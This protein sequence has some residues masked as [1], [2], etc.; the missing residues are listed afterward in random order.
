MGRGSI[1]EGDWPWRWS[2]E[3]LLRS[4]QVRATGWQERRCGEEHSRFRE[5]MGS[6]WRGKMGREKGTEK[7][8]EWMEQ[9]EQSS[10]YWGFPK[11]NVSSRKLLIREVKI[12]ICALKHPS[13]CSVG[14]MVW[15]EAR[16][17]LGRWIADDYSIPRKPSQGP[18]LLWNQGK[19]ILCSFFDSYRGNKMVKILSYGIWG[20]EG[21][22]KLKNGNQVSNLQG[23]NTCP[24][25]KHER[26][27]H[28]FLFG[29]REENI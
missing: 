2:K 4:C 25:R 9:K 3:A 7:K 29:A 21:K 6:G 10:R 20:V 24:C 23:I 12:I 18:R 16:E 17:G 13:S 26:S 27:G 19:E 1:S 22:K 5:E 11:S 28:L 14:R 8:P 15:Q